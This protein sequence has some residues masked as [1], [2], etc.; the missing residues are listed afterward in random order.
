ML[1][2]YGFQLV[3]EGEGEEVRVEK[4]A[5]WSH[6]SGNWV[7]GFNHNHLR[8]TR[9]LRSL[10]VLGLE[11]EAGAFFRALGEVFEGG[12]G[13]IRSSSMMFWYV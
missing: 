6:A 10:R 2:F 12:R 1:A 3:G 9:I 8:I 5:N 4:A 7:R 11:R 13:G